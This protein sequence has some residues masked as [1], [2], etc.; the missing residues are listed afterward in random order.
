M[1]R[2]E[3]IIMHTMH[4]KLKWVLSNLLS[5]KLP[6]SKYHRSRLWKLH[7][8][9]MKHNWGFYSLYSPDVSWYGYVTF[10]ANVCITQALLLPLKQPV[11][12]PNNSTALLF[13]SDI[14]YQ[15][16]RKET[17]RYSTKVLLFD[18]AQH[19]STK[20]G[21]GMNIHSCFSGTFFSK[22]GMWLVELLSSQ[23]LLYHCTPLQS[24]I[25]I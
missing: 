24:R 11:L 3:H 1:D 7:T 2:K 21:I 22:P 20:T 13:S 5:E 10:L 9:I 12:L 4:T 8:S 16:V 18:S 23:L 6:I 15:Q 14:W 19:Q 25:K 17:L